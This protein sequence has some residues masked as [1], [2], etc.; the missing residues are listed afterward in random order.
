LK[1][2]NQPVDVLPFFAMPLKTLCL[3]S[4]RLCHTTIGVAS[5]NI[6]SVIP[7]SI[8][9]NMHNKHENALLTYLIKLS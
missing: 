8:A 7:P 3:F 4:L 5:I 2:K 9:L 1:P 6:Y